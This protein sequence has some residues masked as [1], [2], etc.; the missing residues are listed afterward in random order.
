MEIKL[1]EEKRRRLISDVQYYFDQE[2]DDS[3]G[4]IAAEKL[5]DFF[6]SHLGNQFYLKAVEDIKSKLSIVIEDIDAE[7]F[8]LY[9]KIK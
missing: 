5:I 7:C 6:I 8:P 1:P 2:F 3:L 9:K 4:I